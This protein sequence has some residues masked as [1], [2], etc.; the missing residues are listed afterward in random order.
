MPLLQRRI[1]VGRLVALD[2]LNEVGEVP[3]AR[4]ALGRDVELRQRLCLFASLGVEIK[5]L[6]VVDDRAA[7]Q[8]EDIANARAFVG[9]AA[10]VADLEDQLGLAIVKEG[11]LDVGRLGL[12]FPQ[13]P[14]AQ[15]DDALG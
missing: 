3:L 12:V 7:F 11:H 14:A 2:G 1:E 8:M 13:E 15:A 9:G 10:Q 5:P 6:V 4:A